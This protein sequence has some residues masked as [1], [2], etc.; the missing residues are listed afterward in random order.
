MSITF[1]SFNKRL[2]AILLDNEHDR[3][4]KIDYIVTMTRSVLG[5]DILFD[6]VD[7]VFTY[8]LSIDVMDYIKSPNSIP[9]IASVGGGSSTNKVVAAV[10]D[11]YEIE[12]IGKYICDK[13]NMIC[14]KEYRKIFFDYYFKYDCCISYV[15]DANYITRKEV[16][17]ALNYV[18]NELADR[19]IF[20]L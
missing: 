5:L 13:F 7:M 10:T 11:M 6:D 16:R 12:K 17:Y 20:C 9:D 15:M 1:D 3:E 8:S 14:S 4:D 2:Y 19:R 18:I